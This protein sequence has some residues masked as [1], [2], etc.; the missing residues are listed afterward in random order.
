[1][2]TT[3]KLVVPSLSQT[4]PIGRILTTYPICQS[5]FVTNSVPVISASVSVWFL[6]CFLVSAILAIVAKHCPIPKA[7]NSQQL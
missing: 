7:P 1:M 5:R 2:N 6:A 3:V 4:F